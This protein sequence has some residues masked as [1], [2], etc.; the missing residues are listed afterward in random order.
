MADS[1]LTIAAQIL[2]S[3]GQPMTARQILE[4][5]RKYNLIPSRLGGATM[6]KTLQARIAEDIFHQRNRSQFY[7]TAQGV[8]YLRSQAERSD[9]PSTVISE[10]PT[11]RR[12]QPL[13]PYRILHVP[14]PHREQQRT[15]SILEFSQNLSANSSYYYLDNRPDVNFCPVMI[16]LAIK[17]QGSFFSFQYSRYSMFYKYVTLRSVGLRA[18]I[19]EYDLDLLDDDDSG[20]FRASVRLGA[21]YF[22]FSNIS[23]LELREGFIRL[24]PIYD[25]Q[26]NVLASLTILDIGAIASGR[27]ALRRRLDIAKSSWVHVEEIGPG[28]DAWSR[29]IS[30]AS[31][32]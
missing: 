31:L 18:F 5:A 32:V 25:A 4:R 20:V 8:Y 9:L 11:A 2:Q 3:S 19:D 30:E 6:E 10:H 21:R 1:Y 23:D 17:S 24:A 15:L 7:R 13:T 14:S 26:S 29:I 16:F 28:F 12:I 27:H 22:D